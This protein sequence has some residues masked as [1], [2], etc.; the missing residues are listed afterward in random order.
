MKNGV[1]IVAVMSA[2][3]LSGLGH[4]AQPEQKTGQDRVRVEY[5]ATARKCEGLSGEVRRA[6]LEDTRAAG[7]YGKGKGDA[8]P[9]RKVPGEKK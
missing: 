8:M 7:M 4:A 3:S 5:G 9:D 2:V 6:C 1:M